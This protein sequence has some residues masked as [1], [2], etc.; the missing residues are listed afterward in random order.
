LIINEIWNTVG[1]FGGALRNH[2]RKMEAADSL[3]VL[4]GS[5]AAPWRIA[6]CWVLRA[7]AANRA[8]V[9][10]Y[11]EVFRTRFPGSSRAWVECLTR[12][13]ATPHKP[14]LVWADLASTRLFEVRIVPVAGLPA[15]V[16]RGRQSGRRLS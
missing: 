3:A 15:A 2:D 12:G 5:E 6:S 4:A 7:T 1:D 9:A 8:L 13:A 16:A 11:P 10:R 14:G